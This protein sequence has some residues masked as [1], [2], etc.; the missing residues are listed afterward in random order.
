MNSEDIYVLSTVIAVW[1]LSIQILSNRILL[2]FFIALIS[3]CIYTIAYFKDTKEH[4]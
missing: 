4:S 3:L 1:G 2:G